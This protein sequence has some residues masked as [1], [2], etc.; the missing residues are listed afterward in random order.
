MK[1]LLI[2]L[3]LLLSA[4]APLRPG[5]GLQGPQ[6]P[7]VL[8]DKEGRCKSTR[9]VLF[10]RPAHDVWAA[11]CRSGGRRWTTKRLGGGLQQKK[12]LPR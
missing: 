6:V 10:D 8:V 12:S 1:R 2:I 11:G 3:A 4:C 9:S 7:G 5:H